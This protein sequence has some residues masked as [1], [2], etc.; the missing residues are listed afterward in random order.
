MIYAWY[1]RGISSRATLL[2][3]RDQLRQLFVRRGTS[4]KKRAKSGRK[5]AASK[6][7]GMKGY[8]EDEGVLSPGAY[9]D[10]HE[11]D[12]ATEPASYRGYPYG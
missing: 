5:E 9:H 2:S 6:R 3:P 1:A 8:E 10:L 7:S 12:N 11:V 4:Q